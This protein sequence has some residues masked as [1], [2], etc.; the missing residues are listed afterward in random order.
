MAVDKGRKNAKD[1]A[2]GGSEP[3]AE[4]VTA[5]QPTAA[6]PDTTAEVSPS[7]A[8]KADG[9]AAPGQ[10][11]GEA[12]EDGADD[13]A[14][15]VD[16]VAEVDTAVPATPPAKP[17]KAVKKPA[18]TAAKTKVAAAPA[19]DNE[20]A[21]SAGQRN[22][23]LVLTA[24]FAAGVL[25]VGAITAIVVFYLQARDAKRE[26]S[27]GKDASAAACQFVSYFVTYDA[28]SQNMDDFARHLADLRTEDTKQQFL[29]DFA[30]VKE[31][32]IKQKV[33]SSG[34]EV[35]CGVKEVGSGHDTADVVVSIYQVLSS[36][37]SQGQPRRQLSGMTVQ[38]QKSDGKWL[39]KNFKSGLFSDS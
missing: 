19:T 7:A 1:N 16:T 13:G 22:T 38:M 18:V 39:T 9:A 17:D 8:P 30:N 3:P 33:K 5:K 26:I 20:Q 11:A 31:D 2:D 24:A 12:V 14:A 36:E 28:T 35:V 4:D 27:A 37:T 15:E 10:E 23:G 6:E 34:K 21:P 32:I 29:S 25:L